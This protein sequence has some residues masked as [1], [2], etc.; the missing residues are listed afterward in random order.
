M[1]RLNLPLYDRGLRGG[2]EVLVPQPGSLV[3]P[4]RAVPAGSL[5]C[6]FGTFLSGTGRGRQPGSG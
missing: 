3:E 4:I 6:Y 1:I 2:S 5:R